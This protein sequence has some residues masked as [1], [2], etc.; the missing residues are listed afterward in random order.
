[1]F[2]FKHGCIYIYTC[3]YVCVYIYIYVWMRESPLLLIQQ[4]RHEKLCKDFCT[5]LNEEAASVCTV[6]LFPV[7]E[8]W[9]VGWKPLRIRKVLRQANFIKVFFFV[10]VFRFPKT[11]AKLGPKRR[12][13]RQKRTFTIFWPLRF[14]TDI[15][16]RRY[17]TQLPPS[18]LGKWRLL[19]TA[20]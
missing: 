15:P 17:K 20:Y 13:I 18:A 8:S 19:Q 6:A 16:L 10:T 3:V 5:F 2:I 9:T 7:F 4:K 11:N 12:K 14:G 1:M